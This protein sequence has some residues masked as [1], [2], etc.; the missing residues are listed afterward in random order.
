MSYIKDT[1][2]PNFYPVVQ[3]DGKWF[4]LSVDKVEPFGAGH[5]TESQA[6]GELMV[7]ML[8]VIAKQMGKTKL[9]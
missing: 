7:H 8:E 2:D 1:K 9:S 3:L 6:Y 5:A 4:P